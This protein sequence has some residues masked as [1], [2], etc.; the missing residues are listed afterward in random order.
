MYICNLVIIKLQV[1]M[2][3]IKIF[4]K[5]VGLYVVWTQRTP[6]Y[7]LLVDV[8]L[9]SFTSFECPTRCRHRDASWRSRQYATVVSSN[10]IR[11]CCFRM[12]RRDVYFLSLYCVLLCYDCDGNLVYGWT[13]QSHNPQLRV[14]LVRATCSPKPRIKWRCASD[15][16]SSGCCHQIGIRYKCLVEVLP[17]RTIANALNVFW[18][19]ELVPVSIGPIG[20]VSRPSPRMLLMFFFAEFYAMKIVT[21]QEQSWLM[22]TIYVTGDMIEL[23]YL[24]TTSEI[25]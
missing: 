2:H 22:V 24:I 5:S 16:L 10:V 4:S 13:C 9:R 1:L 25:S 23:L 8:G 15:S 7:L 12:S 20:L 18:D 11:L 19:V 14:I 21:R 6:H 3:V 17:P